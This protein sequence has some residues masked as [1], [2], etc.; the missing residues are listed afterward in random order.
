MDSPLYKPLQT[1]PR[2]DLL[3]KKKGVEWICRMDRKGRRMDLSPPQT[4]DRM[5]SLFDRY[6][7]KDTLEWIA[8][9]QIPSKRYHRMDY[10]QEKKAVEWI[11]VSPPP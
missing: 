8:S 3:S 7:L 6:P 9:S 5:D 4:I 11:L 1:I 2:M 10:P